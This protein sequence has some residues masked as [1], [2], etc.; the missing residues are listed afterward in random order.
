MVIIWLLGFFLLRNFYFILFET[1]PR[2][3]TPGKRALG[4][5]V[6][7]RDGGRL[8]ADAIFAR[9]AMRELEVFLPLT[10]LVAASADGDPVDGWLDAAGRHLDAA[11]F[12]LLPAVQPRPPAGRRPGGRHLGGEGAAAQA[13]GRPRRDG[14]RQ[15]G[16]LR[17]PGRRLRLHARPRSTPMASRSCRCWRTCC[18]APT[19]GPWPRSPSASAPR[20]AGRAASDESD[21]AFLDAYYAALRA[22][23]ETRLLFGHR[24]R[25]Q[26]RQGLRTQASAFTRLLSMKS[27]GLGATVRVQ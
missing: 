21:Y 12:V 3:A 15:Q 6:A 2:A 13:D 9:N 24:R 4:L 7:A 22:R 8:T 1:A 18:A 20:S 17:R 26:V 10:F 27:S 14:V 19:A 11:I 23:L 16:G 5:R 25:G